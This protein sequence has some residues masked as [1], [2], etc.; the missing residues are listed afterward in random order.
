MSTDRIDLL[1]PVGRMVQGDPFKES[2]TGY[3]G[4]ALVDK[5]NNPRSEYF[6]GIAIPKTDPGWPAFWQTLQQVAAAG[7]PGGQ[8]AQQDFSWK[9]KDGDDPKY[10]GREGFAGCYIV[11][12]TTGFAITVYTSGGGQ[13]IVDPNQLKRGYYIRTYLSI[14]ANGDLS[15][16]GIFINPSMVELVGYGE[17]IVGG[18]DGAEVFG[19]AP[20]AQLPPGAS[21]T[22]VGG[23]PLAAPGGMPPA[24]L[25]PAGLPPAGLPPAGLPPAGLPPAGL[26]P[27][28]GVQPAPDFLTPPVMTTK[29]AGATYEAFIAQGWTDDR[30]VAEG[31]MTPKAPAMGDDV[32]Y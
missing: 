16:P 27:A 6:F 10:A 3:Q 32:P 1:T 30:L 12:C 28:G 23:A 11:G 31:Y 29:A 9:V 24:G 25:L 5:Q 21:A 20:V 7:F 19:G 2:F 13:K 22:P 26:P 4:K 15:K 8:A 14:R 17:E 18:P